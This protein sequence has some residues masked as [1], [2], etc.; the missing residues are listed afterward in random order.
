MGKGE[1]RDGEERRWGFVMCTLFLYQTQGT[2]MEEGDNR[3]V[4]EFLQTA[5]WWNIT[6]DLTVRTKSNGTNENF[7]IC[8]I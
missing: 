6:W 5:W 1:Q 7:Q 3:C 8:G 2:R 4:G